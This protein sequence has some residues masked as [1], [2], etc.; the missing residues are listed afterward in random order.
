MFVSTFVSTPKIKHVN[1]SETGRVCHYIF[2]TSYSSDTT[3]DALLIAVWSTLRGM[4]MLNIFN[5]QSES[6]AYL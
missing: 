2:G 3:V 1:V 5:V 4:L 6:A